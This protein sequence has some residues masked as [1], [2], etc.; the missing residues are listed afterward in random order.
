ML[1]MGGEIILR[2]HYLMDED[3]RQHLFLPNDSELHSRMGRQM[4]A[5]FSTNFFLTS[6]YNVDQFRYTVLIILLD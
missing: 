1:G 6:L 3:Y 5:Y 4:N 2:E